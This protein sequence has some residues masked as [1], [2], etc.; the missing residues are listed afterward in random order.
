MYLYFEIDRIKDA[1]RII[2]SQS[3]KMHIFHFRIDKIKD[4]RRIISS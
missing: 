2:S 4:E 1:R 3:E